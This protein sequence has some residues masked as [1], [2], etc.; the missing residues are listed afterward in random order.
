M[1]LHHSNPKTTEISTSIAINKSLV[2]SRSAHKLK[3]L[4]SLYIAVHRTPSQHNGRQLPHGITE[5]SSTP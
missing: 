2:I 4:K 1:F 5:H 3:G